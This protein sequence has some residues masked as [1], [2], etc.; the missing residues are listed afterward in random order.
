MTNAR[1]RPAVAADVPEV[2]AVVDVAF[3]PYVARI[4]VVP[5]PMEADHAANVAAGRVFVAELADDGG[6]ARVAGLVVLEPRADHLYLDTVAVLP[7]AQGAGLG[8][9]LLE[10]AEARARALGL[11]EIRLFTNAMMWENQKIYPR[12]GYE[13][14]ERRATGPYDRIHYR[15]R[16]G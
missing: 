8:R 13:T 9:L 2:R 6:T 7:D 15:K 1:I 5:V 3:R 14:V 10:F 11:P 16:L 12:L 4:G